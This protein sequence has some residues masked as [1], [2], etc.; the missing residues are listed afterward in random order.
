MHAINEACVPGVGTLSKAGFVRL[1]RDVGAATLVADIDGEATGFVLCMQEGL[2]YAS[3]NYR[4]ISARFERFAYVDRVAVAE[5]H[6]GRGIGEALY[7]ATF[8]RFENERQVLLA[9]V[10]LAPPNPGSLRFHKRHGF[11]EIGERWECEGEKGVVY[12]ARDLIRSEVD[13]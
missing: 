5:K 11:E 8:A 4:W 1:V 10:N 7:E 13:G 9:E 12:L 2:D 3:L 6:R